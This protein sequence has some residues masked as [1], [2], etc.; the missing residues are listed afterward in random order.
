MSRCPVA[1]AENC[2]FSI[3]LHLIELP[4]FKG[5]AACQATNR[6]CRFSLASSH[7]HSKKHQTVC[8]RLSNVM[9]AITV[10][11]EGVAPIIS[12][13][14]PLFFYFLRHRLIERM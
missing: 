11:A 10:A 8:R 14:K 4:A 2:V 7:Q 6:R 12:K 1:E 13:K 5:R 3:F 9:C